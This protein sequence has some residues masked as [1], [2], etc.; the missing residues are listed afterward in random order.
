MNQQIEKDG[1]NPSM[2][3]KFLKALESFFAL[4]S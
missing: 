3:E 2:I 1:G 4:I